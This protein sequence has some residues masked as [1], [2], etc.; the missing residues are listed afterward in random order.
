M[1]IDQLSAEL[2]RLSA[3]VAQLEESLEEKHR[4][5]SADFARRAKV[6]QRLLDAF[7]GKVPL[8]GRDECREL[9]NHLGVPDEYR[10]R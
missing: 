2:T 1:D 3:R 7:H 9:A 4:A 5:R 6:E 10:L 8:P